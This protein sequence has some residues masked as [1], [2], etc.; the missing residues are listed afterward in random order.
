M[1]ENF[2]IKNLLKAFFQM[3]INIEKSFRIKS[4]VCIIHEAYVHK[5]QEI[6]L[7]FQPT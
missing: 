2:S 7:E 1:N 6:H 5:E 4:H 3:K